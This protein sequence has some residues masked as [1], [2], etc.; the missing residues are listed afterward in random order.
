MTCW[1]WDALNDGSQAGLRLFKIQSKMQGDL[2]GNP[3]ISTLSLWN[4]MMLNVLRSLKK[5]LLAAFLDRP[6]A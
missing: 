6:A 4:N 1:G 3:G 5:R 2:S